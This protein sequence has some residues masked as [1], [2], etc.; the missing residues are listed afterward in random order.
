MSTNELAQIIH[1]AHRRGRRCAIAS[2]CQA[3]K[4][5]A[6]FN[7]HIHHIQCGEEGIEVSPTATP[8]TMTTTTTN[9][10]AATNTLGLSREWLDHPRPLERMAGT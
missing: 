9:T 6:V 2:C 1:L 3:P 7:L 5:I 10:T 8:N 4:A